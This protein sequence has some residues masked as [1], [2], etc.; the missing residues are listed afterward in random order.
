MRLLLQLHTSNQELKL[1]IDGCSGHQHASNCKHA[2]SI[3]GKMRSDMLEYIAASLSMHN[4][5]TLLIILSMHRY[6]F[7]LQGFKAGGET[8]ELT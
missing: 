7:D 1:A 8:R 5:Q 2:K 3:D 6:F 4:A